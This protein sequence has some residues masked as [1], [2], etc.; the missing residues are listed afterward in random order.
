MTVNNIQ[1]KSTE[2]SPQELSAVLGLSSSPKRKCKL[3]II[4]AL[5]IVT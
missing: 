3:L 4:T 2:A 5:V 1:L